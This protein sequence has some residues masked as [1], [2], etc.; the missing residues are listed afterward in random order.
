MAVR[1]QESVTG[2]VSTKVVRSFAEI[3]AIRQVWTTWRGDRDSDIEVFLSICRGNPSVLRPHVVVACRSGRP[4][5]LLIGRI[6]Q[7]QVAFGGGY[8]LPVNPP[9]RVLVFPYGAFRG[10][11]SH[12]NTEAVIS[13]VVEALGRGE[14]DCAVFDFLGVESSLFSAAKRL[15]G[16][17]TRDH[18]SLIQPHWSMTLPRS[19][20]QLYTS[21]SGSHRYELRKKAKKFVADFRGEVRVEQF[22]D[23]SDLERIVEAA[24]AVANKTYQRGLGVGFANTDAVR[25]FLRAQAA[26]GWLRAY[27]LYV[28][29][30]P[31]AFWIGAVYQQR[32]YSDFLGFDPEYSRYSPGT[33]LLVK[34]LEEFC[35]GDVEE[36]DFGVG[37]GV[38]KERF[39]NRCRTEATVYVFAP[40]LKGFTLS[41]LK[42]LNAATSEPAKKF[43]ARTNLLARA[44]KIWRARALERQRA[45]Q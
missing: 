6:V 11:P 29:N 26:N 13:D 22:C 36:V 44:K 18:Y 45:T 17:L 20:E 5:A 1:K 4:E 40:S 39:G 9:A 43:L 27:I 35:V 34:M 21:F 24:E 7:Q 32:F 15:P 16:Y 10:D 25:E 28:A 41:M 8:R 31:C 3:E 14:A 23:V 2:D 30:A 37:D 38:Y 33:Y 19:V 12:E 42:T